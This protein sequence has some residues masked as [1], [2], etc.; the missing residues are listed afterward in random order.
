M[1]RV[2][3][4]VPRALA[5]AIVNIC[6]DVRATCWEVEDLAIGRVKLVLTFTQAQR[7]LRPRLGRRFA[8][9]AFVWIRSV[10][11]VGAGSIIPP[12]PRPRAGPPR[13]F[14]PDPRRSWLVR[15]Q[16]QFWVR[17]LVLVILSTIIV[18]LSAPSHGRGTVGVCFTSSQVQKRFVAGRRSPTKRLV[19][20]TSYQEYSSFDLFSL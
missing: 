16:R 6:S 3:V 18:T 12:P 5:V 13:R 15:R 8:A 11:V 20:E 2:C 19:N 14:H 4:R 1:L 17:E 9:F 7:R 10:E